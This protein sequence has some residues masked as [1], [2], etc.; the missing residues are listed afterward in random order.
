[1]H[2]S[3]VNH[4]FTLCLDRMLYEVH[5]VIKLPIFLGVQPHLDVY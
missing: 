4:D 1:M 3:R 5:L 2:A